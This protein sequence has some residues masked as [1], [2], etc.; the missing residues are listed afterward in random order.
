MARQVLPIVGLVVGAYF[1]NPQLG[2]I[3][4]AVVGNA[5][6]PQVMQGPKIGDAGVQTSAEG[7]YRPIIYGTAVCAGNVICRGNRTIRTKRDQASKGGGPVTETERVYWTYAIRITGHE[8]AGVTRIWEDEKLVYDIRPGSAILSESAE[9][10]KR[11]TLHLGSETQLPDPDLEAFLGAGN[12]PSYRGSSLAIFPNYDLTD[13][14]ESIPN[15]RFEVASVVSES[16][17]PSL[18]AGGTVL[19]GPGDGLAE[20]RAVGW[21]TPRARSVSISRDGRIA[22]CGLTV[23][24]FLQLRRLNAAGTGYDE[25]TSPASLPVDAVSA[26]AFHPNRNLLAVV[27]KRPGNT[28]GWNHARLYIYRYTGDAFTLVSQAD[29]TGYGYITWSPDGTRIAWA[30]GFDTGSNGIRLFYVNPDTGILS[31]Q[32]IV[33]S[34][35]QSNPERPAQPPSRLAFSPNG[36]YLAEEN[37]Q[38]LVVWDTA[39]AVLVPVQFGPTGTVGSTVGALWSPNGQ[40]IY[41]ITGTAVGGNYVARYAFIPNNPTLIYPTFPAQP[42]AAPLDSSITADGKFLALGLASNPGHGVYVYEIDFTDQQIYPVTGQP[43]TGASTVNSVAW[44]PFIG[45]EQQQGGGGTLSAIVTSLHAK[46][47]QGASKYDVTEL[48]DTVEGI[49]YAGDYTIASAIRALA[50][51]YFF[52]ASEYDGKIHYIK[53]GKPVV[54]TL[55]IDDL[56]DAPEESVRENQI[57]YPRVLHM[58]YQNPSIGYAPAKAT[59][60]RS[61]PDVRVVGEASAQVPVV[62][63]DVA[64]AAQVTNKLHKIAWAEAE[65]PVTFSITDDHL[66]LVC[67]DC[68]GLSLRSKVKRLRIVSIVDDPG[69]R[70]LTCRVDRQSAYTSS[71]TGIPLPP[72]NPPP[73]SLVG[74][75]VAATLD[76]PGIDEADDALIYRVGA[77]GLSAAWT[78]AV[79]QRSAN[80]GAS[81]STATTFSL[82]TVIGQLTESFADASEHYTDTTNLVKV[83]LFLPEDIDSIT[84]AEFLSKGGAFAIQSVDGSWELMQYRDALQTSDYSYTLSTLLRGRLNTT[85]AAHAAGALIV[86]LEYTKAVTA[87]T[88]MI[89]A[90]LTHRAVS[91]GLSPET[92]F[93]QDGTFAAKSQTEWPVANLLLSRASNTITATAVPR[94]RFGTEVVPVRSVHWVAY[95]WTATAGANSI[96]KDTTTDATTF[97]VTG[98]SSPVTVTVSQVNRYTG[99]GPSVSEAIL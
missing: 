63:S 32:K 31:Y 53:R 19:T 45:I 75:T 33:D 28:G 93:P 11:F 97:D 48:T 85:T 36:R 70:K 29:G 47:K 41:A 37:T 82:G 88:S 14:R 67:A 96:T 22:S 72:P 90:T 98:W 84:D 46:A 17:T 94:H 71:L 58:S 25:L 8:I 60:T 21:T 86:F 12:V 34:A 3:I 23:S 91:N 74:P 35:Y 81:Y 65:G 79:V 43:T 61:S 95:R 50:T 78:G 20:T 24:P 2:Y 30:Q 83:Q 69:I 59:S 38:R 49:T 52:D 7:V 26:T 77:A 39:G 68:I 92:A 99:A 80:A 13:R 51:P 15:Y 73:Q 10:A 9:F 54:K 18:I 66:D 42:P 27:S 89:G 6:D 64:E 1:G 76:I 40:F 44:S 62:Y 56:V 4:G 16:F 55:T 5:V 87:D 57:E